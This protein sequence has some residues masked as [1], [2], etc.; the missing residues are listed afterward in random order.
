MFRTV[1]CLSSRVQILC[2]QHTVSSLSM[3][4]RGGRTAQCCSKYVEGCNIIWVKNFVHLVGK[5]KG[6]PRQAEVALVAPGRLRPRI[7]TTFGTTRVVGPQPNAPAA[8]TPGEIPGTPFQ[9]LSQ[10]QGT[11]F[12]RKEPSDTTGDRSRDRPTSSASP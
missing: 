12:C 9:R 1:L 2:L 3:S 10:P 5:S 11:W 4:G 7:I 6:I 8:F